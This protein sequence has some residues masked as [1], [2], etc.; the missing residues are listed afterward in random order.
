MPGTRDAD[1]SLGLNE[2]TAR[3]LAAVTK[4]DRFALD[5]RRRF[6]QMFG[7]TVKG[8]DG[9]L[10][11]HALQESKKKAGVKTDPELRP[12]HL[13]PLVSKF[14]SIYEEATGSGFPTDPAVKLREAI[15]AGC[16]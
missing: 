15:A 14:L 10:F 12:E 13:R 1:L 2:A 16:R 6:I 3:G 9:D 4:D 5:A 11:E 7:K 8:I